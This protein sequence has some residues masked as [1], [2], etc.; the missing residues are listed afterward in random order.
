MQKY[1]ARRLLLMIPTLIGLTLIVFLLTRFTPQDTVDLILNDS[2]GYQD[3]AL[4]AKLRKE[5]GLDSSL[6]EQY[7][8]WLGN[9]LTGDLGASY[10]SGRPV[11]QELK[12]RVPVSVELGALALA[13]SIAI[14]IPIGVISA[15]YQDRWL[16]Y[17]TRGV[18]VLLLAVPS[19]W[20]ALIVLIVGSRYFQWA[21]PARYEP[22]WQDIGSNLYI[23]MTPVIILGLGLA[24]TKIRLMRTQ[25]LEVL[26][27]DYIRTARAKGLTE[28]AVLL[29]HAAKNALIPVVTIIG[30][31]MTVLVAGSVILERI[32]IIPGIGQYFLDAAA[33]RD[34]PIVQSLTLIIATVIVVSNLL[35][36]LSYA[37]L[38]PRV[39]YS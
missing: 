23:M 18:S 2:A 30:L 27:Q 28:M 24:G 34:F 22:P 11:A 5:F 17:A 19:F 33:R 3:P 13:F 6:P 16:D 15:V 31:Q 35:V 37:Y 12:S 26:R 10:F 21:P 29:R 20:L 8:T 36:D 39:K 32:F 38:D 1:V 4:K 25:M 14:G 9:I 7:I